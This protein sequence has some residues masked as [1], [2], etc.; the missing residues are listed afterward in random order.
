MWRAPASIAVH[1]PATWTG[2]VDRSEVAQ[3][4]GCRRHRRP[5]TT[6]CR[7]CGAARTCGSMPPVTDAQVGAGDLR[8]GRTRYEVVGAVA[9]LAV[10]GCR[11]STTACRRC[12]CAHG[13]GRSPPTPD[14]QPVPAT[15]FGSSAVLALLR[16]RRSGLRRRC[17]S[18][19]ASR[20]T[21]WRRCAASLRRSTRSR[22]PPRRR[23]SA[24]SAPRS[25]R[26]CRAG[27]CR[28]SPSTTPGA[29]VDPA[30]VLAAGVD[31]QPR[32]SDGRR[33]AV[34]VGRGA[35]ADLAEGVVAPAGATTAGESPDEDADRDEPADHGRSRSLPHRHPPEDATR[36]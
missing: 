25:R 12:G 33:G 8:R 24:R 16:R 3:C 28:R 4:R 22:S 30:A 23:A 27:R 26:R 20:R 7:R 13:V 2:V 1:V 19:R 15:W 21:G 29:A 11:P 17:P 18:T 14:R 32:R 36:G 6:P 9:D 34:A 5:S 10:E 31:G 35:V